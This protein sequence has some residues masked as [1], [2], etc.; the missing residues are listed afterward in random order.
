MRSPVVKLN[1]ALDALP[2]WTAAP[3][4]SWPARATADRTGELEDAQRA[5]EVCDR[6]EPAVGCGEI[7]RADG[8]A[9]R[10]VT[11]RHCSPVVPGTFRGWSSR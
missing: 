11:A 2:D 4:E 10:P 1:A 5:F 7:Y 9:G 6:G 8:G 3:G